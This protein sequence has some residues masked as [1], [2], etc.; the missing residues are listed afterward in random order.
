MSPP[1]R[2]RHHAGPS[3]R[4]RCLFDCSVELDVHRDIVPRKLSGFEIQPVVQDLN[5]IQS[6]IS[7]LKCHIDTPPSRT[8]QLQSC[9]ATQETA[10]DTSI[11]TAQVEHW[12][13]QVN[14]YSKYVINHYG[15]TACMHGNRTQ[16]TTD[17]NR[18]LHTLT[19][20]QTDYAGEEWNPR[21]HR[22]AQF[23]LK[24]LKVINT[25]LGEGT[26][27]GFLRNPS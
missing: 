8:V 22:D 12:L 6:T 19:H 9:Q 20:N 11:R 18:E 26:Q 10:Y 5:P 7:C 13:A 4:T 24:P 17:R 14:V 1:G 23:K 25:T 15:G 16:E 2:F 21:D 3:L 27:G